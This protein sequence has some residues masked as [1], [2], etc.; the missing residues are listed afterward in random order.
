MWFL[1]NL[2][3]S[4]KGVEKDFGLRADLL[5]ASAVHLAIALGMSEAVLSCNFVLIAIQ[6]IPIERV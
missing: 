1:C 6:E 2:I 3:A 5:R 4:T